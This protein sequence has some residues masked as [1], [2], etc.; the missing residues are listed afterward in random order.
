MRH[1]RPAAN[2][3]SDALLIIVLGA[4]TAIG[5]FSIDT[6]LPA[7]P[8][9]ALDLGA[10]I[11]TIQLSLASFFL[12]MAIGQL[13]V[14]PIA[15]RF[16][17][18][19]PLYVGLGLYF[20]A[21]LGCALAPSA[22]ALIGARFVQALGGSA[23]GVIARA[24]VRDRF[25]PTETARVFSL[26]TLVMG[27]AP[28]VAPSLG[29]V[30]LALFGWRAIFG[31]LTVL[32]ALLLAATWLRLP[33]T[34]PADK[35]ISLR[36]P[37]VLRGFAAIGRNPRFLQFS[38]V[39]GLAAAGMFAYI[40]ASSFVYIEL[41]GVP[42]TRYGWIFGLNAL[43][44]VSA[45]Q[46]NRVWLRRR[47]SEQILERVVPVQL[48]AGVCLLLVALL[49]LGGLAAML[50]FNFLFV[51]TLGFVLP[52]TTA[53]GLAPFSRDAGSASALM[54]ALQSIIASL[55]ASTVSALHNGTPV[56]MALIMAVC[57]LLSLLILQLAVRQARPEPLTQA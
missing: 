28:I 48:A 18:K 23:G 57:G 45:G 7:L 15:D 37:A 56:P 2:G 42:A 26:L 50:L 6:Y 53:L 39:G 35:G 4:L 19:P 13:I 27:I 14:G 43:G 8:N 38:L 24:I 41:F 34:R 25:P 32:A 17:R 22:S 36:L 21:T 54:G 40:A 52:N 10:S 12:G 33:E 31:F 51:A 5:P 44:L 3:Q 46:I 55:A 20:V 1:A 49:S 9:V 30:L 47:T 29:G 11:S 16:G